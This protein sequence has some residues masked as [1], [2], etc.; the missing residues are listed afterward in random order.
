[1]W[2][3]RRVGREPFLLF[4]DVV[5]TSFGTSWFQ[6]QETYRRGWLLW[7][8]DGRVTK[9]KESAKRR[10]SA[11]RS[12]KYF[13]TQ[14]T[15]TIERNCRRIFANIWFSQVGNILLIHT[16]FHGVLRFGHDLG[17]SFLKQRFHDDRL[18]S[19]DPAWVRHEFV[20]W[21]YPL[22][23]LNLWSLICFLDVHSWRSMLEFREV[24]SL[25][26]SSPIAPEKKIPAESYVVGGVT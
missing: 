8:T 24:E 12:G 11:D 15:R 26:S 6:K 22:S 13:S 16:R 18:A 14:E 25:N 3:R 21:L 9:R 5:R 23:S 19:F 17:M 7:I 4:F 10:E 20:V 2:F 1:M